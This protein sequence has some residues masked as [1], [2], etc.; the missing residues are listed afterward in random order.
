MLLFSG[1]E[2]KTGKSFDMQNSR[3][4]I[5]SGLTTKNVRNSC[6]SLERVGQKL[7]HGKDI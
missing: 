1:S 3:L 6:K 2:H 4:C 7:D 5:K